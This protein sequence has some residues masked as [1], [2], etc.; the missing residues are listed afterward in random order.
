MKVIQTEVLVI[1]GGAT[2]TG[3]LRDLAMR[4]FH[5]TL[6]E[7]RDLTHGTS[8]RFHG[9]LH[10]GGRYAVNDPHAAK[11][12]IRE[13]QILRR[14]MPQCIE[15][16]GGF[17]V[18]TPWDDPGYAPRFIE[19]CRQ[20]DIPVEE[21]SIPDMIR[22]EPRLNPKITHCFRVPDAS[23]DSF[24][25]AELNAESAR[26]HGA[27]ILTY[28]PVIEL[29]TTGTPQKIVGAICHDLINDEKI[30]FETDFI[31][32]AAGAW[33]GKIVKHVGID[34]NIVPGK[35]VMLATNHRLV[36]TVIN[37]CRPPTDGD[38]LVP[39]HTVS[40]IGTTDVK[41]SNPDHFGI[42]PWEVHLC[43]EEGEKIIP[44]F[45]EMRMLRAWAGVRPLVEENAVSDTREV[46]RAYVLLDHEERD[47]IAGIAT[48]TSGKWTTYRQMAESTVDLVAEKLGTRRECRTHLETLPNIPGSHG[49]PKYHTLGHRLGK[50]ETEKQYGALICECELATREDVENAITQ[51]NAKTID[52]IR[53]D[54]RLGMGPC[55]GGFC[56]YRAAGILNELGQADIEQNNI[57]LREYLQE[58]WKGIRPVLWGQQLRQERLNE[59]IY[60][61]L[62]NADH[63][64]GPKNNPRYGTELYTEGDITLPGKTAPTSHEPS[65]SELSQI[66][67]PPVDIIIIGAG[68]SGMAAAL[69]PAR[70]GKSVRVI[71]KGWGSVY[72]HTGCID[73]LGYYPNDE[74]NLVLSP[75]SA[76]QTLIAENP[77]HPYAL[78]GLDSLKSSLDN[79]KDICA[80][81]DYPLQGSLEHN[82]LLPTSLGVAR[83]T[84][85]A[86]ITMVDGDLR[87]KAPILIVG[88]E[89]FHDFYANFIAA[90]LRVAG[91]A[92]RG[93][94]ISPASLETH[95]LIT[96]RLLA[97]RFDRALFRQEIVESLIP[98]LSP[99]ERIGFP[100]VL[101]LKNS[102]Q[103]HTELSNKLGAPV[104]EIPTL[105]PSIPGIRL[106][107]ILIQ[108]LEQSG[109]RIFDGIDVQR[110]SIENGK[111]GSIS[112]I[113]AAREQL[114]Y[115]SNYV[116]A[117]GGF[118]GGGFHADYL[119]NLRE[120]IFGLEINSPK[121]R[122]SWFNPDFLQPAGHPLFK[123]G[124]SVTNKMSPTSG[125]PTSPYK[126]LLVVG[127][128]LRGCDPIRERS[129]EGIA[130]ATGFA[131]GKH[132]AAIR[133]DSAQRNGEDS[134]GGE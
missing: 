118:L 12:C 122:T 21:L 30:Q 2:G 42:E 16:T 79:I 73:V 96:S 86:P 117:T 15:D 125:H 69:E 9:L 31:V 8:G 24:L 23:V 101:G 64:P 94:T 76:I 88:F 90:N 89:G 41:V 33:S 123:T 53:R 39:A 35:G 10:S 85:L 17:F 48:I 54:I 67:S 37:R 26:L 78:V 71:A 56:T 98:Q 49:N 95:R 50:V 126:N 115:A 52:D 5:S 65:E 120:I 112:S 84:C 74:D 58:R 80:A 68:L 105:P 3:V 6:V 113:A 45:K 132:L 124:I 104:F 59:L 1:G 61:S 60:L 34:I 134:P 11:E 47:G 110:A 77:E 55:Q 13:N 36:N 91:F 20:A 100:A 130:L 114:H 131:A 22:E 119:G 4:G 43:L 66:K 72:W 102:K 51:G 18:V 28:H 62:F 133:I 83:P 99:G 40:V 108:H 81:A 75:V 25:G 27:N 93:I 103:N 92:A 116:L 107:N 63:L 19:G 38:I 14:I 44:G 82:F 127:N 32:N 111:V 129:F 109:V 121:G 29:I 87:N 70:Q 128:A 106:H 57:A 7:K 97:E 46:T